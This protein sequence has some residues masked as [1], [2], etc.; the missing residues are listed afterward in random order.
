MRRLLVVLLSALAGTVAAAQTQT[1]DPIQG[2]TFRTGVDV[3][4]VDV[5]VVDPRGRPIE[6]LHAADFTV[7]IDGEVRRVVSAELVKVDV[8]K[9]KAKV[10]DKTETFFTT[11]LT[12][13]EG[14]Q[15]VLAIDQVQVR[16][17][18]IPGVLLP[19]D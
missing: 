15:I 14:R 3:I 4:A 10:A 1:S 7:K 12:P 13:P 8:E 6:D 5:A 9:A 18:A 17:G 19:L 16:P 2:P 11:N